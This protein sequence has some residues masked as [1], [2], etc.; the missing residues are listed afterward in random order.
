M[1]RVA[2]GRSFCSNVHR[3]GV[4]EPVELSEEFMRRPCAALRS[5]TGASPVWI[6]WRARWP[7]IMEVNSSPVLRALRPAPASILLVR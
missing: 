2:Q 6:C 7:Q 4:A 5:W 3:G 1:R